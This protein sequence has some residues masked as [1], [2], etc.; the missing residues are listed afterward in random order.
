[1]KSDYT[2]LIDSIDS[3]FL[4]LKF[5]HPISCER[6]RL[7]IYDL[8]GLSQIIFKTIKQGIRIK[9]E[10]IVKITGQNDEKQSKDSYIQ[11]AA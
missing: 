3:R 4:E 6:L 1:M 2:S 9:K 5:D 11:E 8:Y 7:C 10:L